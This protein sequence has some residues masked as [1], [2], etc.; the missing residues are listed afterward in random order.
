[1][2]G[3]NAV[4]TGASRGIGRAIALLFA[5]N[6]YNVVI[7]YK[8][9]KEKAEQIKNEIIENGGV[10]ET[11]RADVGNCD[12][13][14]KLIAFCIEKF[15]SIDVLVNNAGIAQI[16]L[17]TDITSNEWNDMVKTN[18]TGVFNCSQFATKQMLKEHSGSI[19]NISSMW[20]QV[21][22]S[23]EVHYSTVKA[24]II[25]FTKAL[26]KELAPSNIRVNCIAPGVIETD[27][28]QGFT[29]DELAEI[30]SEIPIGRFGTPNDVA[31]LALFLASE[32]AGY[33]TGQII[34]QNG[35]M[36]I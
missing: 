32:K 35:G 31:E 29:D 25:G 21:G 3:K 17:F 24:G 6:G 13:A 10:A 19:I 5:K 14:E 12:E 18:L 30:K 26:A 27:M 1:M 28:M 33:I 20:G 23:C 34:S 15:G 11:Y 4:I 2:N 36:V 7:N 22:A 8:N 16:K 9:T